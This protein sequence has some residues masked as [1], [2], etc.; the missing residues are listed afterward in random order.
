VDHAERPR[1]G[2]HPS[3]ESV[4]RACVPSRKNL[5][6]VVRRRQQQCLQRLQFGQPLAGGDRYDRLLLP[7][8][9]VGIGDVGFGE[10]DRRAV[11]AGI[12]RVVSE[13]EIGRHHLRDAGDRGSMLVRASPDSRLS[14]LD[15]RLA[16]CRPRMVDGVAA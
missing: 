15:G 12:E 9:A 14:Y 10:R 11:P 3:D 6:D 8:P 1:R 13:H 5:G 2:V 16:V 4:R 7:A